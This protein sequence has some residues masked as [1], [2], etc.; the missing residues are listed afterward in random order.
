M[1]ALSVPSSTARA[2]R[3]ALV[4]GLATWAL[5][6]AA[7]AP[8][9]VTERTIIVP[10]GKA[11]VVTHADRLTRV[12]IS[13]PTVAEAVVVSPYEVLLNGKQIGTTTLVLWDA[14]GR[15]ELFAVEVTADAIALERQ[16]QTL[17]PGETIAVSATGNAFI[18][19][20]SVSDATV[21]RRAVEIAQST[22]LEV[23]DNMQVPAPHQIL[24]QVRFAEVSRSAIKE[25]GINI[26]RVDPLNLRGDDE[27]FLGT[28]S[29]TPPGANFINAPAGPEQTF[30]DVVN[31]YLFDRGTQI[32]AFIR[33]LQSKGMFR[34]LAEP[35]L[36]ALD[37]REASFL[38][39][40]EFPYPVPQGSAAGQT[41]TIVFKEFGIR[42]RF[43][44]NITNSGNIKLKVAPEVSTL[45]F[46]NGLQISGFQIPA[47]LSRRA[48]TEVELRDGQTFAIA[49]LLDNSIT[50]SVEKFPILGDIPILGSL[51]SSKEMQQNRTELLVLVT[52]RLVQP[53]STPPVVPTGEPE[54]WDWDKSLREPATPLEGE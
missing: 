27:G 8:A 52:P 50:E 7:D 41:V 33:A 10:T 2:R 20:G 30:S 28:G 15:R 11:T 43:T 24:L 1:R 48:E 14:V 23:V 49:G 5:A 35:N 12:S 17:F 25:L 13:N 16:F 21:A 22:G 6:Q 31:L 9:Q 42:L 19:T 47:L 39:G 38:A 51:F 4:L 18:L 53:T 34:S 54:T 32:G 29:F 26:L 46:A 40:G 36:L 45:D 37:G 44:P 3:A